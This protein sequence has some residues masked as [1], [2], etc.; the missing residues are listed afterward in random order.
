MQA[1]ALILSWD[2]QLEVTLWGYF[3]VGVAGIDDQFT[4]PLWCEANADCSRLYCL[5]FSNRN[6]RYRKAVSL[7]GYLAEVCLMHACKTQQCIEYI[8]IQCL[9]LWIMIMFMKL[10]SCTLSDTVAAISE[11]WST[12]MTHFSSFQCFWTD[13]IDPQTT[14]R[15]CPFLQICTFFSLA[16]Y[17]VQHL[18]YGVF[19]YHYSC[20]C[21]RSYPSTCMS[22]C[23]FFFLSYLVEGC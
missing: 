10:T 12:N 14:S 20:R 22:T 6:C 11:V 2:Y 21:S 16:A 23:C 13:C 3:H 8:I 15:F 18:H 7:L 19:P 1:A 9:K 4:H 17:L 5:L